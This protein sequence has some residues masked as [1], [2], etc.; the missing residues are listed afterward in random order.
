MAIL[1]FLVDA[2][3]L[4]KN[5]KITKRLYLTQI[6]SNE[7]NKGT[8]F[9]STFK[10]EGNKVHLFFR[11]EVNLLRYS[12]FQESS[13]LGPEEDPK[14]MHLCQFCMKLKISKGN[15]LFSQNY[16]GK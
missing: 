15:L 12:K 16:I 1:L 9:S 3:H 5:L 4:I 13:V 8:L 14:E 7:K 6:K 10:V 11:F 2:G